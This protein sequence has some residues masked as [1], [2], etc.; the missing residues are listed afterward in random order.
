MGV[1]FI[2]VVSGDGILSTLTTYGSF[3]SLSYDCT[4]ALVLTLECRLV[5]VNFACFGGAMVVNVDHSLISMVSESFVDFTLY[6]I[7]SIALYFFPVSQ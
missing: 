7:D 1:G 2:D 4:C 5:W 3:F 6:F